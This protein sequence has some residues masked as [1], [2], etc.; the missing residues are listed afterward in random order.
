MS[1]VLSVRD[2][3]GNFILGRENICNA[4][5]YNFE[6]YVLIEVLIKNLKKLQEASSPAYQKK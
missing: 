4:Q 3:K 5:T 2:R 1:R 6:I